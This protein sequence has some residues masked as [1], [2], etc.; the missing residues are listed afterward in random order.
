M[1][2]RG[3][4]GVDMTAAMA[5]ADVATAAVDSGAN[6]MG[7]ATDPTMGGASA[8]GAAGPSIGGASGMGGH[9]KH[10]HKHRKPNGPQRRDDE[11]WARRFFF[12]SIGR[13]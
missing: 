1:M 2:R 6:A 11:L 10:G 5:G 12:R 7:A 3:P 9:H 8:T 13:C 4:G